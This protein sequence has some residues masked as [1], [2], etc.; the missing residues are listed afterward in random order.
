ME[1]TR[2]F[3]SQTRIDNDLYNRLGERWY[4]AEDDPVALLRAERRL[5]VPWLQNKV[6][7]H[8][9]HRP[10]RIL[11]V[12]CGAGLVSNP[13][14]EAGHTVTG[15]DLSRESLE[16]AGRHDATRRVQYH[17]ANAYDIPFENGMFDVVCAMDFLEHVDHPERVVAEVS[18]LLREGGLFFFNTF[19]RNWL[20]WLV[21]IK[22]VEWFVKNTPK[23]MHVLEL[24]IPP[25]ELVSMCG[26][27]SLAMLEMTGIR[28][29]FLR[30]AFWKMLMTGT[31]STGFTFVFTPSLMLGYGGVAQK[32]G[33][34]ARV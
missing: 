29:D 8:F 27:E 28:P 13:L 12:G 32:Q 26:N 6:A 20:A 33:L 18:R 25:A 1:A 31:V 19:N 17:Q 7:Q 22:G 14:S 30:S 9:S 3:T 34:G 2:D 5:V 15:I 24:F 16:V 11:D 23:D 10:C 21:V 4:E